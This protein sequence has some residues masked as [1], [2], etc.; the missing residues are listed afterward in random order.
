VRTTVYLL[1]D[2]TKRFRRFLDDSRVLRFDDDPR[3]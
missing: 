1:T 2:T 3:P